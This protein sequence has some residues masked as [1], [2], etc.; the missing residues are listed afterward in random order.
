MVP[1]KGTLPP[2]VPAASPGTPALR[3]ESLSCVCPILGIL[4]AFFLGDHD[5]PFGRISGD[6]KVARGLELKA[7][8]SLS[9]LA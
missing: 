5:S 3:C 7:S 4:N 9:S 8:S 1:L 6:I 2:M